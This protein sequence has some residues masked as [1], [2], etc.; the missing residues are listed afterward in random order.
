MVVSCAQGTSLPVNKD[1]YCSTYRLGIPK[2]T[3]IIIGV[4]SPLKKKN[5][6]TRDFRY[7]YLIYVPVTVLTLWKKSHK[8]QTKFSYK[9]ISLLDLH[10]L[11]LVKN[12][13]ITYEKNMK[14]LNNQTYKNRN[15][16]PKKKNHIPIYGMSRFSCK[17]VYLYFCL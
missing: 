6:W 17:R 2:K 1:I 10:R 12:C 9:I 11:D 16:F 3:Y 14:L 5:G 13:F 4:S 8:M 7:R 15:S